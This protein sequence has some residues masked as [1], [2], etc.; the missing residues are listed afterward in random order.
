M[1]A[2]LWDSCRFRKRV[3][4]CPISWGG[5]ECD[6]RIGAIGKGC[7]DNHD[8]EEGL[9]MASSGY[10][11]SGAN[12]LKTHSSK[13]NNPDVS[14]SLSEKETE[15]IASKHTIVGVGGNYNF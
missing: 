2:R 8:F 11:S 5:F 12:A 6:S 7:N 10:F 9:I 3:F 1:H 14:D 4:C 15:R 13:K